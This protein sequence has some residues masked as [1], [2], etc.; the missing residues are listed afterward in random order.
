MS[1]LGLSEADLLVL[2]DFIRS[3][4]N[5]PPQITSI[6]SKLNPAASLEPSSRPVAYLSPSLTPMLTPTH[7]RPHLQGSVELPS[8]L[9]D[10]AAAGHSE[11]NATFEYLHLQHTHGPPPDSL[12]SPLTPSPGSLYE[13]QNAD[14][15]WPVEDKN[16]VEDEGEENMED[17]SEENMEDEGEENMEEETLDEEPLIDLV[18]HLGGGNCVRG[19]KKAGKAHGMALV[20]NDPAEEDQC[21]E[22]FEDV[23]IE[24]GDSPFNES[25]WTGL[26][27]GTPARWTVADIPAVLVGGPGKAATHYVALL[28]E[29]TSSNVEGPEVAIWVGAM[30]GLVEGH[31]WEHLDSAFDTNALRALVYRV[32]RAEHVLLGTKVV[33][34]FAKVQLAIKVEITLQRDNAGLKKG[35]KRKKLSD[36]YKKHIAAMENALQEKTFRRWVA[37]G[38]RFAALAA[39]GSV[40]LLII[41]AA[42]GHY[43]M[44][45]SLQQ[46]TIWVM[47]NTLRWPNP[48]TLIGQHILSRLIPLIDYVR[49]AIP[50]SID[51]IFPPS[52]LQEVGLTRHINCQD[53]DLTDTFFDTFTYK[54][55]RS[56]DRHRPSWAP[57][58]IS[59]DIMEMDEGP[60]SMYL[61]TRNLLS[62]ASSTASMHLPSPIIDAEGELTGD[63]VD[64]Q[65]TRLNRDPF[66]DAPSFRSEQF[67][68]PDASS[69]QYLVLDT[70]FDLDAPINKACPYPKKKKETSKWIR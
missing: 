20:E 70:N 52:W 59:E 25:D 65:D 58:L 11:D 39:A 68:T 8:I 41:I 2:I 46:P 51:T 55:F 26:P 38:Q 64:L 12:G 61:M 37:I 23:N 36:L 44:I 69:P 1:L 43:K 60:T 19:G 29:G 66:P 33:A 49:Q 54:C 5:L 67:Y 32:H 9:E 18:R 22:I 6:L 21:M 3:R 7:A 40:Y 50:L 17:E 30:K 27:A 10:L 35:K 28:A 56:V 62:A 4:A 24:Q 48:D 14:A 42:R 53:F 45:G 31:T 16:E 13:N 34:M 47:C 57:C 63:A 15:D